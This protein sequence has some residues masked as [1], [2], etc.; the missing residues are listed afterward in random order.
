MIVRAESQ[1]RNAWA[2]R[3][4]GVFARST[5]TI[6]GSMIS[7]TGGRVLKSSIG[8]TREILRVRSPLILRNDPAFGPRCQFD[9]LSGVSKANPTVRTTCFGSAKGDAAKL[10]PLFGLRY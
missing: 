5:W 9:Q 1:I 10:R 7:T 2:S 3:S 4:A 8:R 6:D